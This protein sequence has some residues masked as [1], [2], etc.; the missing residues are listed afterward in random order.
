[1]ADFAGR[2]A[3][4]TGGGSGIGQA[5]ARA[6]TQAGARVVV[7]GRRAAPGEETV[8]L[9]REVGGEALFVRTDVSR[10]AEVEALIARTLAA[11]G[12]LDYAC[13]SAGISE[14][15]ALIAEQTEEDFDRTIGVNLKGVWLCMKY[16]I[17]AM[18]QGQGGS[19]VN[20]SSLNAVKA[21][22]T[23][24]FYSA[25]KAGIDSLTRA[26]ALGYAKRGIRVNAI[27]AG[28]F[29]TPMLEKVLRRVGEGDPE[30]G[31]AQ[32]DAAIPLGRIGRPEEIANTVVWLCSE[33]AS[34]V[35]GHVMVVDGGLQAT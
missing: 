11:F 5:V 12:R 22:P 6:F 23:A 25:S 9:I 31:A 13:N 33:A 19:I 21:V 16:E 35:T 15:P 30:V 18:L 29:R 28:A 7:A 24:P 3:L 17:Q 8:R 1:M 2:V 14:A 26:A 27:D 34:Y 4:V 20:I 10:A 32:Y